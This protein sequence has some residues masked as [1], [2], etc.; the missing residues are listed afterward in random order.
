MLGWA[1]TGV[2]RVIT[3]TLPL[4]DVARAWAWAL[5]GITVVSLKYL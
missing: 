1:R 3:P 5:E 2:P 4:P